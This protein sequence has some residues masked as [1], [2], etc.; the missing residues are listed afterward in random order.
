MSNAADRARQGWFN[1]LDGSL[2]YIQTFDEDKEIAYGLGET[3]YVDTGIVEKQM[4]H[5]Q[6]QDVRILKSRPTF[7]EVPFDLIG[8]RAK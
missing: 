1:M 7:I 3:E 2:L 6:V 4:M 5:G 8:T